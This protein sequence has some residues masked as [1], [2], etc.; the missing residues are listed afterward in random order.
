MKSYIKISSQSS[1][2]HTDLW[3]VSSDQ[4]CKKLQAPRRNR[5]TLYFLLGGL[6][7]SLHLIKWHQRN[8]SIHRIAHKIKNE[9]QKD[10]YSEVSFK[11][12]KRQL[13]DRLSP[14]FLRPIIHN[15]LLYNISTVITNERRWSLLLVKCHQN[16]RPSQLIGKAVV[17]I[18]MLYFTNHINNNLSRFKMIR[19]WFTSI[20]NALLCS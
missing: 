12:N 7:N 5:I 11:S 10:K 1:G 6:C 2:N 20:M 8:I 19:S 16:N 9:L 13:P 17:I 18:I 14:P 4:R 3:L 15:L